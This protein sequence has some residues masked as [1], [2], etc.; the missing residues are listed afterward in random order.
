MK[1][2]INVP[3]WSTLEERINNMKFVKYHLTNFNEFLL[4][5]G[6]NSYLNIFDFSE[7]QVIEDSIHIPFPDKSFRKAEKINHILKYNYDNIKPDIYCQFDSD[8]FFSPDSYFDFL[9]LLLNFD[10]NK[11]YVSNVFDIPLEYQKKIDYENFAINGEIEINERFVY[12]LGGTFLISFRKLYDIGGYNEMFQYWGGEDDDTAN[13]LVRLGMSRQE[14]K[15]NLYHLP[16]SHSTSILDPAPKEY[17]DK[18]QDAYKDFSI[19]R[20]TLLNNYKI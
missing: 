13:R 1:V 15:I 19:Y 16:H 9:E 18:I 10:H 8:I 7:N 3:F 11:F 20:K 12:G 4:T 6:I 14:Y 2:S 5:M 17:H